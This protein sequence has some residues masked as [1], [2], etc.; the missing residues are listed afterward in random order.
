MFLALLFLK[1]V[2]GLSN[3]C[4]FAFGQPNG[5]D[6]I[7]TIELDLNRY[8]PLPSKGAR[9]APQNTGEQR[10]SNCLDYCF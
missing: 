2:T 10:S 3:R 5:W 1:Q 7:P 9:V 4:M 8:R 6:F